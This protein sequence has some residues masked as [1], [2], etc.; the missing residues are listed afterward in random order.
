MEFINFWYIL[1]IVNDIFTVIGS[2]LKVQLEF[3]VSI[4]L[5]FF[6]F[7]FCMAFLLMVYKESF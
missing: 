7:F 6:F 3:R 4:K 2:A 1:I 5:L